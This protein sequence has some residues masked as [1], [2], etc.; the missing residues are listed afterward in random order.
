MPRVGFKPTI[1]ASKRTKTVQALDH[2]A[3]V[4]GVGYLI[5]DKL[6]AIVGRR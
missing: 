4:T 3:T 5:H 6:E 1:T 2:S